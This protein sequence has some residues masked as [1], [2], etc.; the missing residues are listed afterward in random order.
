MIG[1]ELVSGPAAE[2]VSLSDIKAQARIDGTADDAFLGTLI[3]AA[4][5][6]T[7]QYTGRA[8]LPQSWRLWLD[9]WPVGNDPWWSGTRDGAIIAGAAGAITLPKAPLQSVTEVRV[10]QADDSS[11]V[12]LA[13][14]YQVDHVAQPG[15]LIVRAGQDWPSPGRAAQGIA[16]SFIA[17][18]A[19]AG[20]VPEPIK[21]G[22]RQ[23]VTHWYEQRGETLPPMV[24]AP[25]GVRALLNPYRVRQLL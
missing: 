20:A 15:R 19:D 5:Q 8:L 7:E 12:W 24:E 25:Y 14:A 11:S 2:P 17:G 1:L 9:Q 21:A 18:Y 6:W 16:I 3:I 13:A 4:R 10:Y 22:I 23:L